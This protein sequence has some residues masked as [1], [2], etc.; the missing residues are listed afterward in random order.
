M[1]DYLYLEESNKININTFKRVI[2]NNEFYY[3]NGKLVLKK[4]YRKLSYIKPISKNLYRTKKF[5]TLDIETG[6][7]RITNLLYPICISIHDGENTFTFFRVD[8]YSDYDFI[9]NAF[10]VFNKRKFHNQ[11]VYI[12]N[13]SHFDGVFF[14][15]HLEKIGKVKVLKRDDRILSIRLEFKS[16]YTIHLRDSLLILPSSLSKLSKAFKIKNP[17]L[18]FPIK[19]LGQYSLS[20]VGPIPSKEYFLSEKDYNEYKLNYVKKLELDKSPYEQWS[21]KKELKYY[22]ENDVISLHQVIDK[23]SQIIFNHYRLDINKYL[24]LS[25]I[26]LNLYR[27]N[28]QKESLIPK[29]TGQMYEDI[30]K[31][32]RGGLVDVYLPEGN[33][34]NI[35]D[36]NSE[37][38]EAM[39][40]DMP[41]GKVHYLEGDINLNDYSTFGFFKAEI[42]V[43]NNINIPVLPV[44]INNTTICPVGEWTGWYFS[45]ELKEAQDIY[46][47]KIKLIKGYN[48]ERVNIFNDYVNS[49]YDLKKS[50]VKEDPVYLIVKLLLNM[51]YG[52]FG[53]STY[54]EENIILNQLEADNYFSNPEINV[55]DVLD[56]DNG[57]ELITFI[58]NKD[59]IL[60][61]YD[62][63]SDPNISIA[64]ASAIAGYG[65]IKIN[66]LKHMPNIKIY[67]SDTDNIITDSKLPE[68]LI[69]KELGQLKLE[70]QT[71]KAIFLSPKVYGYIDNNYNSI[72][73]TKGF[74]SILH[75]FELTRLLYKNSYL[76]KYQEKWYKDWNRGSISIVNESY[77]FIITENKRQLIFDSHSKLVNTRPFV[78]KND[79]ILN[80]EYGYILNITAPD[81]RNKLLSKPKDISLN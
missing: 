3:L 55:K 35:Y 5:L 79:R 12:H 56:L 81:F 74:K 49:L 27:S 22:C 66:R 43:G 26:A 72:V 44:K 28:F 33:I 67:Y 6:K 50:K 32:Y 40:K 23:F 13:L 36:V 18:I 63:I 71:K 57:K 65:R 17:K 9:S 48:F 38:P 69:G 37:Y 61:D 7:D 78:L 80:R 1:D 29:I 19:C 2:K 73:K 51:L 45:E 47:Y 20:Y 53:M 16:N 42:E 46:G 75:F 70:D 24:T 25:S 14:L 31:S 4:L 8:Y 54:K 68:N 30:N 62:A 10:I 59:N 39:C 58:R 76:L 11:K 21:L 41:G 52:R 77:K 64:I 60:Q 34:L 15:K